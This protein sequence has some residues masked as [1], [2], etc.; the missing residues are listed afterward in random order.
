M[1]TWVVSIQEYCLRAALFCARDSLMTAVLACLSA[2]ASGACADAR[3]PN[4][5]TAPMTSP[6]RTA[7][8]VRCFIGCASCGGLLDAAASGSIAVPYPGDGKSARITRG[9]GR[10]SREAVTRE[11]IYF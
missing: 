10:E 3:V 9:C 6:L 1:L 5:T 8:E 11:A 2:A 7:V 4:R